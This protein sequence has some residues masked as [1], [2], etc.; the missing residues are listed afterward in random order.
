MKPWLVRK[1]EPRDQIIKA[2]KPEIKES[3]ERIAAT[4]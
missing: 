1:G 2:N 4:A 3:G